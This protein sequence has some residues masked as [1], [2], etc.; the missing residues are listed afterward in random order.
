[1]PIDRNQEVRPSSGPPAQLSWWQ[2]LKAAYLI[3]RERFD[4]FLRVLFILRFHMLIAGVISI[5]LFNEQAMEA[6]VVAAEDAA[7]ASRYRVILMGGAAAG[8]LVTLLWYC[9]RVLLNGLMPTVINEVSPQGWFVR[10]APRLVAVVPLLAL[11]GALFTASASDLPSVPNSA[12]VLRWF[13]AGCLILTVLTY[14]TWR[15]RRAVLNKLEQRRR[16]ANKPERRSFLTTQ[17]IWM[18]PTIAAFLFAAFAWHP[19][20]ARRFGSLTILMSATA[21]WVPFGSLLVYWGSRMRLP[22]LL[23]LAAAALLW[24]TLD[25][26]DNHMVRNHPVQRDTPPTLAATFES[27]LDNR[28]DKHKYAGRP[29]PVFIVATEGGGIYAAT[30]TASVLG[31]LQ[32]ANPQFRSHVF[33]ISGVSGGSVGASVFAGLCS[34]VDRSG[35]L[36]DGFQATAN[37]V[38]DRDFLSPLLAA[39]LFPDMVQRLL[40]VRIRAFDRA[41]ALE[42]GLERA[43]ATARLGGQFE[44]DFD[45]LWTDF[46]HHS[47]PA[48]LLNTTEVETGQRVVATHL[49]LNDARMNKLVTFREKYP[50]IG[51]RLSTAA[52]L[53]ARFPIVTPAG[54]LWAQTKD[55]DGKTQTV[56]RRYVDG[57]YFENSGTATAAELVH[58]L[59]L[60][61]PEQSAAKFSLTI[62]RIGF[63]T[64]TAAPKEH[65]SVYTPD[66]PVTIA[67]SR[68]LTQGL[69]ELMSPLRTLLNTRLARGAASIEQLKTLVQ[70]LH[71]DHQRPAA[72]IEF[73]LR[74]DVVRIPLGWLLS[75]QARDSINRQVTA[76]PGND[77]SMARITERLDPHERSTVDIGPPSRSR[78]APNP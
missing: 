3:R 60:D 35:Q 76:G 8:L 30:F 42:K 45:A 27:W 63:A 6:M 20:I 49:S 17:L 36:N 1:V 13:G 54:Y 74:E 64:D 61:L 28:P 39:G 57:G 50:S 22:L 52:A 56:K 70:T 34:E 25:W 58:A 43:W 44:G 10:N 77:L 66:Q 37:K 75:D 65:K 21:L 62:I 15:I 67:R 4:P 18:V 40:P 69:G 55:K 11:S 53:S 9:A 5:A 47:V 38:L 26:N 68:Y 29:Y 33:A 72:Y 59:R 12:F 24:S 23:I 41:L 46:A 7:Q 31:A 32:D 19:Q 78:W 16:A 48:L 51:M 73:T 2:R 14:Q 71:D